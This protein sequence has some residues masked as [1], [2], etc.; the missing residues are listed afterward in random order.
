MY[1]AVEKRSRLAPLYLSHQYRTPPH[2]V[3]CI[4][5][6][7]LRNLW[8]VTHCNTSTDAQSLMPAVPR[9]EPVEPPG[10]TREAMLGPSGCRFLA[11]GPPQQQTWWDLFLA[12]SLQGVQVLYERREA[13]EGECRG[14]A[15]CR[16]SEC[17]P[18]GC[19]PS[20]KSACLLHGPAAQ[21]L[22]QQM[23]SQTYYTATK[24]A[25]RERCIHV[26][27]GHDRHN[28][29]K[30]CSVHELPLLRSQGG[31]QHSW[32]RSRTRCRGKERCEERWSPCLQAVAMSRA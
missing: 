6:A 10:P 7:L 24:I 14:R 26:A 3:N 17:L 15:A 28:H 4:A 31:R 9:A 23:K 32:Q 13:R 11:R 29:C 5:E 1:Q 21:H 20:H 25:T 18:A 19:R 22:R 8:A 30:A 27:L 2:A 12:Q 16:R